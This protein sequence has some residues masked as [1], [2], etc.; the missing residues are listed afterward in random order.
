MKKLLLISKDSTL[1]QLYHELFPTE[2][3]ELITA[4]NITNALL[5]LTIHTVSLIFIY[6]DQ[7]TETQTFIRLRKKRRNWLRIP[8][9]IMTSEPHIFQFSLTKKDLLF[10]SKRIQ[11]PDVVDVIYSVLS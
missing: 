8:L 4:E 11:P 9:V 1:R 3:F 10:N 2:Q 6:V 5:M 7:E